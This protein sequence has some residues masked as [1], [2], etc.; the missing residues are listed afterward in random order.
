MDGLEVVEVMEVV[1]VSVA[2]VV[3]LEDTEVASVSSRSSVL[4]TPPMETSIQR[5][6]HA[7]NAP[8]L[9]SGGSHAPNDHIGGTLV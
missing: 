7:T 3:A 8:H 4:Y 2:E 1:G 6:N 5:V 9:T